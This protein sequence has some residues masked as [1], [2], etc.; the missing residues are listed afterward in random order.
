MGDTISYQK[1]RQL[2]NCVCPLND[3]SDLAA[4]LR[5]LW[6]ETVKPTKDGPWCTDFPDYLRL[7]RKLLN[8]NFGAIQGEVKHRG[9][10][11]REDRIQERIHHRKTVVDACSLPELFF[12][13]RGSTINIDHLDN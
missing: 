9:S 12:R 11:V 4:S 13:I 8:V 10:Q 7:M 6:Q 1:V 5:R 3:N 2:V